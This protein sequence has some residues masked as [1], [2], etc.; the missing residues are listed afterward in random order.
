LE[1]FAMPDA[2]ASLHGLISLAVVVFAVSQIMAAFWPDIRRW[3][4]TITTRSNAL[5]NQVVPAG[6]TFAIWG[7]IFVWCMAFAIWQALPAQR[8]ND[9]L[10]AVAPL[11]AA[12][13]F[14]NTLWEMWVPRKGLDW[15]S[16]GIILVEVG[17]SLWIVAVLTVF[18]RELTVAELWLV[19]APL[20][21]FAG[22]ASAATFV[23]LAST[24][25]WAGLRLDPRNGV[26]AVWI[27][28]AAIALGAAVSFASASFFYAAP[29]AWGLAGIAFAARGKAERAG[30]Q[31]LAILAIPLVLASAFTGHLL[32]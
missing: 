5:D 12:L 2:Y 6:P 24:M 25:V 22:W 13:F 3:P 18:P 10:R 4:E 32:R 15:G 1:F 14:F 11:A 29:I 21:V 20:F 7:L 27:L 26:V 23:N 28:A 17:L 8:G 19:K 31:T 9:L 30:V 16:V